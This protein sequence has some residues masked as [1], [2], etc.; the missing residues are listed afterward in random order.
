VLFQVADLLADGGRRQVQRLRRTV[1]TFQS[2]RNLERTQRIQ[3][4][5][6]IQVDISES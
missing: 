6:A 5:K 3:W 1:E 2:G 4:W